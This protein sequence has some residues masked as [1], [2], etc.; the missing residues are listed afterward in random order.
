D[1]NRRQFVIGGASLAALLVG[2]S[3]T[4][5]TPEPPAASTGFPVTVSHKRG[6]TEILKAPKRVV[7]VGLTE[8]DMLLALGVMP[9][10]TREWF[11]EQPG[12]LWP[13]ART[14]AGNAPI[15]AV[16][17]YELNYEKIAALRPDL[18]LGV[19]W[20]VTEDEYSTLSQ[21]APTVAQ[22]ADFVDGGTPWQ[23]QTR[24]IGR[25]LG[26]E[27][28]AEEVV[29]DVEARFAQTREEHPQFVGASGIAAY[30][31][32]DGDLGVYGP[33]D[34]RA[35]ILTSLGFEVPPRL[36]E[37]VGNEFFAEVS[38]E[39]LELVEADALVW[40]VFTEEG[41]GRIQDQPLYRALN[42][43]QEGRDLF[44]VGSDP[45]GAAYSFSTPLSL[46][47]AI[48]GLVPQLVAALDGDPAT[49]A[50]R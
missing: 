7:S 6:S 13:W 4:D 8:Q 37:L 23:E 14:A 42:V 40:I 33:Q 44:V 12:A 48:D 3:T 38:A 29:A 47:F 45:L 26:R 25:A 35:R 43:A 28:R 2:C 31:F 19:S 32:G 10:A 41:A 17:A 9:V 5:P 27:Q 24:I 36:A 39:Q 18:I 16:L 30:D 22:S 49:V 20:G 50:P 46:P 34:P 1:V 15:P 21:I 11:G